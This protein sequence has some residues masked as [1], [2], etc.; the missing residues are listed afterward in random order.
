MK[1]FSFII[2]FFLFVPVGLAQF[3]FTPKTADSSGYRGGPRLGDSITQVWRAGIVIQPGPALEDVQLTLP[4]PMNWFEQKVVSVNEEK[5]DAET[6]GKI[7]YIPVKNGA[8]KN[9][10]AGR[11]GKEIGAE[12]I[13]ATQMRLNL[14]DVKAGK[15]VQIILAF[16]LKNYALLPPEQTDDYVIP[17]NVPKEYSQFLRESP[18]IES[19]NPVFTKMYRDI[20]KDR[21]TAWDKV[22]GLYSFV[23]N[24]VKY[25]DAGWRLDARGA[26]A[27]TRMPKGQW[28]GDCKDMSCLFVALCRA[29]NV[30]ARIVRVPEHCYAEFYLELK[31]DKKDKKQNNK[32]PQG[33]WFPCQVSGAY[34]F[35]GIPERRVILQKGDSFP[36]PDDSKRKLLW[37]QE[38]FEGNIPISGG[39][40]PKFKWI[41]E[42]EAEKK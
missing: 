1:H 2:I 32:K 11:A 21:K 29:G 7:E 41:H 36:D 40:K 10:N 23:Q 37:L 3:D 17:K 31:P 42:A 9:G 22:E 19:D 13:T 14:G 25:D 12:G 28:S 24:N 38:C 20:T 27:V 16:E 18:H 5:T 34:S 30:P 35:G 33:F 15:S 26:L 6:A 4:V 39:P 8:V